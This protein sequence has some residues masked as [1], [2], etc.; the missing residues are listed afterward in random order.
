[1][2]LH[3]TILGTTG[4][5]RES[6]RET[7][8]NLQINGPPEEVWAADADDPKT[9]TFIV[10]K[11]IVIQACEKRIKGTFCYRCILTPYIPV[12]QGDF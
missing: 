10:A 4:A 8:G 2:R 5:A 7:V 11:K 6:C 1:M 3:T 12:I 9:A